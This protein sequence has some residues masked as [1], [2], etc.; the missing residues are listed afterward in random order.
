MVVRTSPG[1]FQRYWLC[2]GLSF[3][4]HR[5]VMDRIS[6]DFGNDPNAKDLARVLRLPA[7]GT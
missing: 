4:D 2:D 7:S 5:L 3:S 1:K 6:R